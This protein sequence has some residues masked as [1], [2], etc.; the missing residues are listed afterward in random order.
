M[1]EAHVILV[2]KGKDAPSKGKAKAKAK[3]EPAVAPSISA[4]RP[5][6]SAEAEADFMSNLLGTID[7]L[8]TT[9]SAA[10]SR[11]RKP[12]PLRDTDSSRS[13]PGPVDYITSRV[14]PSYEDRSS[15]VE[16]VTIL[17]SDDYM[18]SPKKKIRVD[19]GA[20]SPA[21]ERLAQLD[22]N[23]GPEDA[24]I[25]FDDFAYDD[26]DMD[27]FM[28]VDEDLQ[29]PKVRREPVD[30]N[31][32]QSGSSNTGSRG[33]KLEE[34]GTPAWLAVYDSLSIT[35]SDTLEPLASASTSMTSTT[36]ND[37]SVL[38]PDGSLR[39]FWMDYLELDGKVYFT[40]KLRD[41]V[42]GVWLSCCVTVEGLQRNLFAL[43]REKRV[44]QDED[45]NLVDT[46]IV[47]GLQDV[48]NDFDMIRKQLN[49]KS[50]KA[51][52]VK[53]KYVFGEKE[54]PRGE[55]QWLKVVYGYNGQSRGFH[56][57]CQPK[58]RCQL[59]P[60]IPATACSPSIAQ[61]FGTNT[62]A[63][64]LLVLKRKIMGPCWLQIKNPKIEN[65]GVTC[66]VI[67]MLPEGG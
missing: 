66:H 5:K 47:P 33:T 36:V 30:I 61:V 62:S 59:E 25:S 64:E 13:S 23:S 46:D 15:D 67:L 52:F 65:Q 8:P 34:N 40:G 58:S 20:A 49:I 63:F 1:V 2:K 10:R 6:I 22:F 51:K 32:K 56:V 39:F 50:W 42:T 3:P 54:V 7:S 35:S 41:K 16:E 48:Y 55:S 11:K 57:F 9:P 31:V 12:S 4:Y 26:I 14:G 28:D 18:F 43:P 29:K 27:A 45:G 53:R 21:T 38:E 24:D 17:S 37:S 19:S 44:E 60:Q